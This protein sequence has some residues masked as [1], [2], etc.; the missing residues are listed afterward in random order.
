MKLSDI[1]QFTI[2]GHYQV[3]QSWDSIEHW[4][5][6]Q[7]K[8]NNLD[9]NPDFQRAHVWTPQQTSY[10]EFCL[11]GG[12]HSSLIRFNCSGWLND[13]RGPFVLVDGKQRLEA[14]RKFMRDELPVFDGNTISN[15]NEQDRETIGR[16]YDLIFAVNN[17]KTRR[18]VLQWYIDINSSGIIHTPEEI[19]K[20]QN[21]LAAEI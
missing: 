9:L 5:D 21:L 3:N 10:V 20:V 19:A 15:F 11:K 2:D 18:E 8:A 12:K 16:R 6:R 13:F 7:T 1:R 4:I 14:V 17:L